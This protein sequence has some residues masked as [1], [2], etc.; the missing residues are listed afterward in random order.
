M[1]NPVTHFEI[2]GR[3]GARLESFYGSLFGWT[4]ERREAGGSAYG[5]ITTGAK[6]GIGG[7]I[8]HEPDGR[9]ELVIYVEVDD[10]DAAVARAAELGATVRIPPMDAPEI[11]FALIADPEGNPVGLIRTRSASGGG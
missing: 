2:A 7:G 11:R 1:P 6:E 4:S 5:W 10:V 8:R 3:D 9:A